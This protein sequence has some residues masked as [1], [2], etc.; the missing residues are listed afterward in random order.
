MSKFKLLLDRV[1][2]VAIT[3]DRLQREYDALVNENKALKYENQELRNEAVM[4]MVYDSDAK[5]SR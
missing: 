1:V 5:C 4:M 3:H 2:E